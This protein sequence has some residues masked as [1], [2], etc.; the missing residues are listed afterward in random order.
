VREGGGW[1]KGF[2]E[3]KGPFPLRWM[4]VLR[5]DRG[6]K[7]AGWRV[8][9]RYHAPQKGKKGKG[10]DNLHPASMPSLS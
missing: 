1:R 2:N 4:R 6:G 10:D 3:E 8:G 7:G 5:T 9:G